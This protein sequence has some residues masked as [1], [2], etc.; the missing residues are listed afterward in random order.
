MKNPPTLI[1][2]LAGAPE[3]FG[4]T[5]VATGGDMEKSGFKGKDTRGR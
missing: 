5:A 1:A 2:A 3:I 4:D